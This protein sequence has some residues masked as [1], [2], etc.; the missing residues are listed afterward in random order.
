MHHT[1]HAYDVILP[2]VFLHLCLLLTCEGL[3]AIFDTWPY[4]C[5]SH[6]VCY[7]LLYRCFARV[8]PSAWNSLPHSL[9]LEL[10]DISPSQFRR[11]LKT[12]LFPDTGTESGRER[13]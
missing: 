4:G 13:C 3:F 1:N 5:P 10:L 2:Q 12:F 6:A 7:G 11:R 8:G 9:R